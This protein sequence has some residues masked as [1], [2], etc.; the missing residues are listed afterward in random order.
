MAEVKNVIVVILVEFEVSFHC[1]ITLPV[2]EGVEEK[3]LNSIQ[4]KVFVTCKGGD[5]FDVG[6]DSLVLSVHE[7][8]GGWAGEVLGT[9]RVARGNSRLQLIHSFMSTIGE[10]GQS[11]K[12]V[13]VG[14]I[15]LV[16]LVHSIL[17]QME[18]GVNSFAAIDHVVSKLSCVVVDLHHHSALALRA[19][20]GFT[21]SAGH[22][23]IVHVPLL[24]TATHGGGRGCGQFTESHVA[25]IVLFCTELVERIAHVDDLRVLH[26]D[27]VIQNRN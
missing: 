12:M 23:W 7:V 22:I 26:V 15:C 17:G 11:N 20:A 25:V 4:A 18:G 19:R 24:C 13:P 9:C 16:K 6:E 8:H 3:G 21:V 14:L 2:S 10:V 27:N 5:R 1:S